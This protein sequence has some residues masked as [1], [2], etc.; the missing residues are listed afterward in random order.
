MDGMTKYYCKMVNMT[1][2]KKEKRGC[3]LFFII[4]PILRPEGAKRETGFFIEIRTLLSRKKNFIVRNLSYM[5][6]IDYEPLCAERKTVVSEQCLHRLGERNTQCCT[7]QCF[8][9]EQMINDNTAAGLH[10]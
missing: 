8:T 2:G 4:R 3:A 6:E 7:L 5:A 1:R 9:G 10:I